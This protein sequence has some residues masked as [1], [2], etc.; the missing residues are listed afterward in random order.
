MGTPDPQPAPHSPDPSAP[1]PQQQTTKTKQPNAWLQLLRLPNLFTVPG[2][3]AA[4]FILAW[5]STGS[6]PKP[7]LNVTV[8]LLAACAGLLLY[9]AGLVF[10]DVFDLAEDRR[11]RPRRPL[12][13][14]RISL[15]KAVAAGAALLCGGVG[16]AF[17]ASV[18]AGVLAAGLGV[19][20]LLYDALLKRLP[21]IG[22]LAMGACRGL[23]FLLGATAAGGW[24]AFQSLLILYCAALLTAYVAAV[25]AIARGETRTLPLAVKRWLPAAALATGLVLLPMGGLVVMM[26]ADASA[27]DSWNIAWDVWSFSLAW[28]EFLLLIVLLPGM[29]AVLTAIR[30]ARDLRG[31]PQPALIQRTIGRLIRNLLLIQAALAFWPIK[32]GM[33]IAAIL[34]LVFYPLSLF[35]ARRFYAS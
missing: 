12:P 24:L 9:A 4:G 6:G 1:Q 10:N 25:T 5:L 29:L 22:P 16:C 7:S 27:M 23:N 19:L 32:P 11:D 8:L 18:P 35:T 15:R 33:V 13:S 21:L 20:I 14:G 26:W 31:L 28:R 34:L 30:C 2:D 3:P 17:A